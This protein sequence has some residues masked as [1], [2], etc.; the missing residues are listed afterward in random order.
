[1]LYPTVQEWKDWGIEDECHQFFCL[2]WTELFDPETP[3]T[4]QVRACNVKTILRE[5]IDASRIAEGFDAYRGVMRSILDEAFAIIKRDVILDNFYP[6]VSAYL[7]PWR[8]QDIGEKAVPEIERLA[9][10]VLGNLEGYWENGVKLVKAR[11][12][13]PEKGKKKELYAATMNL[14]IETVA[15]GRSPSHI[16]ERFI[17]TVLAN[18]EIEFLGRVDAVFAEYKPL[19][20]KYRC[21]FL[22][23]GIR[24]SDAE[25]L[26]SDIKLAVGR[27]A[28][29]VPGPAQEFFKQASNVG[30]S[31][32]VELDA[33]DPEAARRQAEKRLGELFAGKNLFGTDDRFGIK[34]SNALVEDEAAGTKTIISHRRLGSH[35]LGNYD[36]RKLKVDLLFRVQGHLQRVSP[37]DALQLAAALEY[38]RL[39]LLATSDE[40]RLVNL[41]IALEALCQGGEGSIIERV[42]TRIAPCVSIDNVRKT[43]VSLSILVKN[44]WT[45][46]NREQFLV[47]LPNSTKD[48]LDPEDLAKLLLLPDGHENLKKLSKLCLAHPLILHRLFR[49]K[50]MMLERPGMVSDNIKYTRQNVEWQIKRIY[51]VRNSIVHTGS[52]NLLLPQ[53]AQHLHCYLVKAIMSVLTDLDR[54]PLWRIRDSLEHRLRLFELVAG[55][56]GKTE[57]HQIAIASIMDPE[58]C[59]V[60][61]TE[62]FA[63]PL[64]PPS[65]P[66]NEPVVAPL[67]GAPLV[68]AAQSNSPAVAP[69]MSVPPSLVVAKVP[70]KTG[71]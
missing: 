42:W 35:Y 63:W 25:G 69:E 33:G 40:A 18:S 22:A 57:G 43:L 68:Q 38:H 56:F 20:R 50:S 62:P 65:K 47:L 58:A 27:P 12:E 70:P 24:K 48:H 49:A 67:E 64:M 54:Q 44:F 66:P 39:A 5:L 45:P 31:L 52:A 3:D 32:T 30:V 59:M 11:L 36:A 60:L 17:A 9:L 19:T 28:D 2:Y 6:F 61:Q 34:V 41:W 10:V 1:M 7:E 16:R 8:K 26:P 14:A 29:I 51:R 4:W 46:E 21:V 13:K 37:T 53:L 71:E 23:E 55:M 15:R